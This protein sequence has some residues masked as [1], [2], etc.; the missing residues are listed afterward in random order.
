MAA[1]AAPELV[2]RIE[3]VGPRVKIPDETLLGLA[4]RP[5]DGGLAG[6]WAP[7]FYLWSAATAASGALLI[8]KSDTA[9][10]FEARFPG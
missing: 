9:L 1:R 10:T 4:G 7:A 6:K 3:A 5:F 2:L 8:T